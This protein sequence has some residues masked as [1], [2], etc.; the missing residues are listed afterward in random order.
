MARQAFR[1]RLSSPITLMLKVSP[2]YR[3]PIGSPTKGSTRWISTMSP[4]MSIAPS[5][6]RFR[7]CFR[8]SLTRFE[9]R[10]SARQGAGSCG[11]RRSRARRRL[12]ISARHTDA[13]SRARGGGLSTPGTSAHPKLIQTDRIHK[14]ISWIRPT[15]PSSQNQ[16]GHPATLTG[17]GPWR[18]DR[19]HDH[20][21]AHR[22]RHLPGLRRPGAL[23][24]AVPDIVWVYKKVTQHSINFIP[25][26]KSFAALLYD[27]YG[28]STEIQASQKKIV[29]LMTHH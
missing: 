1:E 9:K 29:V 2:R 26:G 11:E 16:H 14:A 6:K 21:G 13:G 3:F 17:D 8:T 4:I 28:Y 20:R 12:S 27:R 25:T 18:H 10:K 19:H 5:L 24:E 23:S 15:T 22:H 7:A